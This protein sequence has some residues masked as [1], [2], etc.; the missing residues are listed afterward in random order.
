MTF[1]TETFAADK[2]FAIEAGGPFNVFAVDFVSYEDDGLTM[3]TLKRIHLNDGAVI[4]R[5]SRI[6]V[7]LSIPRNEHNM[8]PLLPM[9]LE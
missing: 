6:A 8:S 7:S 1:F 9:R 2:T 3:G 4:H 5:N